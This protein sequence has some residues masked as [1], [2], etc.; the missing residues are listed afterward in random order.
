MTLKLSAM[1]EPPLLLHGAS[2]QNEL[3]ARRALRTCLEGACAHPRIVVLQSQPLHGQA[4]AFLEGTP[5]EELPDLLDFIAAFKFSFSAERRV[6]GE[7]IM[8]HHAFAGAPRRSEAHDSLYR[9]LPDIKPLLQ[10][11]G[12]LSYLCEELDCARSPQSAA[13]ALG[14]AKHPSC[15]LATSPWHPIFRQIVYRS[16]A[17]S[18]HAPRA[19]IRACKDGRVAREIAAPPPVA[20]VIAADAPEGALVPYE[21]GLEPV[22]AD[23]KKRYAVEHVGSLMQEHVASGR[24]LAF[25]VSISN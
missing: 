21:L 16:D 7:H 14:M 15:G 25:C 17:E 22:C 20:P 23:M 8:L 9:R 5:L 10:E 2:H 6:E 11:E 4:S 13:A 1:Q 24:R 19:K 12:G 18:K 3:V